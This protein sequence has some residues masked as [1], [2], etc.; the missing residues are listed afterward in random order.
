MRELTGYDWP[1]NIRELENEVQRWVALCEGSVDPETL[2][3][4]VRQQG[5]PGLDP[6]DLRIRPRVERLELD[7]IR[8]ALEQTG[9]N[10]TRAA[11]LLG[12]SRYGLQ[13]KLRRIGGG[14]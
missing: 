14:S 10:Q 11:E 2:S 8:R 4:V 1:G 9:G 7:L 3:P 12:L 13:K 5:D 6:D